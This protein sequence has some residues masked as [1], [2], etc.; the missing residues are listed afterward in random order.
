VVNCSSPTAAPRGCARWDVRLNTGRRGSESAPRAYP[1]EVAPLVGVDEARGGDARPRGQRAQLASWRSSRGRSTAMIR[2][3]GTRSLTPCS[4]PHRTSNPGQR[5]PKPR[6]ASLLHV[7]HDRS[8][9]TAPPGQDV[10]EQ[11][12]VSP[13]TRHVGNQPLGRV[14]LALV[15]DV[16]DDQRGPLDAGVAIRHGARPGW[17]ATPS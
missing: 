12:L 5:F 7:R 4:V 9:A 14:A 6:V 13:E 2:S 17:A 11:F 16:D 1:P 10:P 8:D 15:P 3:T